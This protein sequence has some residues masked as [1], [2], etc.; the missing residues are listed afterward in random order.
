M[1]ELNQR[2]LIKRVIMINLVISLLNNKNVS[3]T[4]EPD[5]EHVVFALITES[6]IY[7]NGVAGFCLCGWI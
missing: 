3:A 2:N 1:I 7:L 5:N 6:D 4:S